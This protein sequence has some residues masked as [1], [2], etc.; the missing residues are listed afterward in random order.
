MY[1]FT[2]NTIANYAANFDGWSGEKFEV[3]KESSAANNTGVLVET[4]LIKSDGEPIALNYLMRPD[5]TGKPRVID[6]LLNGSVS[7][8]AVYRAEFASLLRDKGPAAVIER[9]DT[10]F[11]EFAQQK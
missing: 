10:K 11:K 4:R 5:E 2:R 7:Q 8:L 1:S 6:V 3:G 9:L